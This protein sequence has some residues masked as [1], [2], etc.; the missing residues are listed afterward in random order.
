MTKITLDGFFTILA[1]YSVISLIE[2]DTI[3]MLGR[4]DDMWVNRFCQKVEG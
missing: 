1:F 2:V 3:Q 4:Y